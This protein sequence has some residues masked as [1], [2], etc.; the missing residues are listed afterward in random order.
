MH[1]EVTKNPSPELLEQLGYSSWS[2]WAKE[3]S[4][5][6]W[7]YGEKETC[8]LLEGKVTVTPEGGV[9]ITFGKGD[10]VVFPQGMSCTWH[11][12]EAV[13]KHYKFE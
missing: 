2:I 12:Q 5:F 11:V 7:H 13:R 6:T 1:I 4:T 3:P 9:P 10:L 8:L